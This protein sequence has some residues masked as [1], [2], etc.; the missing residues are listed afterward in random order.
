[1]TT[2]MPRSV[3]E[4]AAVTTNL[5]EAKMLCK[6]YQALGLEQHY[7]L[8]LLDIDQRVIRVQFKRLK[9]RVSKIKSH[10]THDEIAQINEE[11][12]NSVSARKSR[13]ST[14]SSDNVFSSSGQRSQGPSSSRVSFGNSRRY[15]STPGLCGAR[16]ISSSLSENIRAPTPSPPATNRRTAHHSESAEVTGND[17]NGGWTS[18]TSGVNSSFS[19]QRSSTSCSRMSLPNFKGNSWSPSAGIV[20]AD[21]FGFNSHLNTDNLRSQSAT[22]G[23]RRT[24]SSL[25]SDMSI[26]D[27]YSRLVEE[28]RMA[29]IDEN[30]MLST[31]LEGKKSEFLDKVQKLIDEDKANERK[32]WVPIRR[33]T[34]TEMTLQ[35][36]EELR[37]ELRKKKSD[38]RRQRFDPGRNVTFDLDKKGG[39]SDESYSERIQEYVKELKKCRYL[40]LPTELQDQGGVITSVRDQVRLN[41][42]WKGSLAYNL[43]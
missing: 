17:T 21:T 37:C 14:T 39:E 22:S 38:H 28:Q 25:T 36:L 27:G 31:E 8:K 10:L 42:I 4:T 6:Q 40:R 15:L 34:S 35:Q 33:L 16:K 7:S 26:S 18:R 20:T 3:K 24:T 11:E 2:T 32:K 23:T 9:D 41:E 12:F 13:L 43:L 19:S 1:M 5:R 30:V 29:L